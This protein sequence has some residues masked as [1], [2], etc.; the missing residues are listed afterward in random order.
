MI[1]PKY[2]LVTIELIGRDSNAMSI[3]GNCTQ[4]ARLSGVPQEELDIFF[5]EATSGNHDH[6]IQTC[7]RW[8]NVK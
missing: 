1:E 2:P 6:L 4:T 3:L 7:M 5:E 8:F